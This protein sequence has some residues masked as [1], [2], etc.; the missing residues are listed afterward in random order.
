MPIDLHRR[1]NRFEMYFPDVL[2]DGSPSSTK[3]GDIMNGGVMSEDSRRRTIEAALRH[4]HKTY[5]KVEVLWAND[6]PCQLDRDPWVALAEV[7]T[8]I[9]VTPDP[10]P[11]LAIS[12]TKLVE[13]EEEV[14][15]RRLPLKRPMTP[16]SSNDSSDHQSRNSK[17]QRTTGSPVLESTCVERFLTAESPIGGQAQEHASRLTQTPVRILHHMPDRA[18]GDVL[19]VPGLHDPASIQHPAF[20][21]VGA[22]TVA[23]ITPDMEGIDI[24]TTRERLK[25]EKHRNLKIIRL[26]SQLDMAIK[27]RDRHLRLLRVAEKGRIDDKAEADRKIEKIREEAEKT[28]EKTKIYSLQKQDKLSGENEELRSQFKEKLMA[29]AKE[30]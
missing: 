28:T 20:S 2:S 29:M 5:E 23:S 11:Q 10:S 17:K 8:L 3:A 7:L 14:K 25:Q 22:S 24:L 15:R 12:P 19:H 16:M 1:S 18:S 13:E 26:Q 21:L 27:Q 9:Q 30:F 4:W 6:P